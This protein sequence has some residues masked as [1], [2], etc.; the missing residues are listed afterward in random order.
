[1]VCKIKTISKLKTINVD[2]VRTVPGHHNDM[3]Y[4]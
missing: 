3:L 2:S 4:L 1:M